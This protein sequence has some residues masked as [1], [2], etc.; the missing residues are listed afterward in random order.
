VF[1]LEAIGADRIVSS[2]LNLGSGSIRSAHGLYPVPGPATAR[3]LQGVPVYAGPQRA[4]LVTPTGALLVTHYA[5]SF[6]PLPPMRLQRIGYGAGSRDFSDTPNVLRVMIGDVDGPT[7]S[8]SVVVLEAEIDDMNPQ[9]FGVLMDRLLADG[10]LDV[11]Y[12]SVQMKKNRPGTLLSVVAPPALRERLTAMI[13]RETTTIGV[14]H[15]E[16][17]RECLDRETIAVETPFGGIRVKVARRAGQMLNA[18]PEFEDCARL[19][20]ER[21]VPLKDV[22]AA[23]LKA[24]LDRMETDSTPQ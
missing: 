5:A 21:D 4:E 23:A 11:F 7:Q 24:F 22:Q 18:S 1:A 17:T 9:I 3:L 10:A 13:F 12:T 2:P 15:R 6:G 8:H 14:R 20:R 19:A 16:M